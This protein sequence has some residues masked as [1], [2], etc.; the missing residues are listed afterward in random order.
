MRDT[1]LGRLTLILA[2]AICAGCASGDSARGS[3]RETVIR[4]DSAGIT[5]V[6]NTVAEPADSARWTVDTGP[7]VT[8]GVES[9][10][11]AYQFGTIR[12]VFPLPNGMIVVLNGQ[13]E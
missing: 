5:I 9:G 4:R 10:D 13:G 8:I 6:E 1:N 2:A 12:G 11:E 7:S 3:G